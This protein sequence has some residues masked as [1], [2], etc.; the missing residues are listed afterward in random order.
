[1]KVAIAALLI[2]SALCA[3]ATAQVGG[4]HKQT[5]FVGGPVATPNRVVPAHR[6]PPPLSVANNPPSTTKKR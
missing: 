3:P 4:A 6:G 2:I 1:M 5:G